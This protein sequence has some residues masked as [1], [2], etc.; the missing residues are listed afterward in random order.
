MKPEC[1]LG[2]ILSREIKQMCCDSFNRDAFLWSP[3]R[4]PWLAVWRRA[5]RCLTASAA[6]C[7]M[8]VCF[9]C[10]SQINTHTATAVTSYRSHLVIS[11]A[12]QEDAI[13]FPHLHQP[14]RRWNSVPQR[15]CVAQ[16][17]PPSPIYWLP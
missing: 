10:R 16:Q 13:S 7:C 12:F 1:V 11:A 4:L 3:S 2:K 14:G 6:V 9:V 8:P 15:Y 5:L 17:I